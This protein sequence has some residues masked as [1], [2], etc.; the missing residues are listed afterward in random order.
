MKSA[1]KLLG[2]Q[3]I[4]Q[5]G[6]PKLL[7][8]KFFRNHLTIVMYHAVIRSPLEFYNWCFLDE[9][10]F[11][12]QVKYFKRNFDV[13]PL[14]VAVERLGNGEI[15]R[16]TAVL[17]FDDGYQNN[18]DVVF[19]I[20]RE[21]GLPATIFL[22]TGLVNTGDTVWSCRLYRALARTSRHMLEWDGCKFDL[23]GP[24]PKAKASAAIRGRLKEYPQSQLRSTLGRIILELGDDPERP[25]EADSP[26]RM[27]S[28]E[29]IAEMAKSGLIEF[30]AH[31][32]THA[33]LSRLSPEERCAEIEASVAAVHELTGRHCD[34]FAYPNGRAQ[35]YD[36]ES[37]RTLQACGVR[38]A[39]T[40]I[41][42]SNNAMT[43]VMELRRCGI[44]ANQTMAEFQMRVHHFT[45]QIRRV[46][47]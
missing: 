26:F 7:H 10:L 9:T 15:S 32:H 43:P 5:L 2:Y 16:P 42:G 35:D 14:S 47:Q 31:T 39:V 6:L 37:I 13:I 18:Y 22:N 45:T 28:R 17:T 3:V 41:A 4:A 36:V 27:L 25:I 30:G 23:S 12:H 1:I 20:L 40:T 29:A 8:R 21:A 33:I 24:G 11:R 34:L 38:A 44:G 19:P 46:L